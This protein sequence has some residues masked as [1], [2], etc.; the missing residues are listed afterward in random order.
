MLIVAA[1]NFAFL[2]RETEKRI[3]QNVS[4][5]MR[6]SMRLLDVLPWSAE[7][8]AIPPNLM[9]PNPAHVAIEIQRIGSLKNPV[10]SE[11]ESV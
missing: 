4:E 3:V 10:I 1:T 8:T 2:S 6:N 9:A 5:S 11:R 7:Q